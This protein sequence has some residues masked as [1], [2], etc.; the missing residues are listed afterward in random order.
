MIKPPD[1]MFRLIGTTFGGYFLTLLT[2]TTFTEQP[3]YS[4][5][6]ILGFLPSVL[7]PGYFLLFVWVVC[8]WFAPKI[9]LVGLMLLSGIY[10][11]WY[12]FAFVAW[13]VFSVLLF[14]LS[15]WWALL[16]RRYRAFE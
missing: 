15:L 9:I 10:W 2:L 3:L 6:T 1:L 14:G 12:G 13:G 5:Y 8:L 7:A 16:W 11:F 4:E